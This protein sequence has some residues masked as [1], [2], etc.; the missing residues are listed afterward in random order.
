MRC[1]TSMQYIFLVIAF[2]K[3]TNKKNHSLIFS[4]FQAFTAFGYFSFMVSELLLE[5]C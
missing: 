2:V 1:T 5:L 4:L 3:M